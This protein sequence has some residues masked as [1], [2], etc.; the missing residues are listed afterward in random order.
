MLTMQLRLPFGSN[1][2]PEP[3]AGR[4]AGPVSSAARQTLVIGRTAFTVVYFRHRR[5]RHY[6][7]R[8]QGDASL[9][10]TVP[11][12]GTVKEAERFVREKA[13]WIEK[14]RYRVALRRAAAGGRDARRIVLR[15][16][17]CAI[18]VEE[19]DGGAVARA[20]GLQVA[21]PSAGAAPVPAIE[22]QLRRLAAEEL[23]RRLLELANA[24]GHQVT[25][26]TVRGQRTR[27]G[28]C[29]PTGR[30]S[31][32]WRLLQLPPAVADYVL[33]H[34]LTHLR[35][36]NHSR[37]FWQELERVCPGHREARAWLK[38]HADI[39]DHG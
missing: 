30:I 12:G 15:G 7:L 28:S 27:W 24:N 17:E 35:H 36:L 25:G 19:R 23:P 8:L 39:V 26:V 2:P 5:A 31:L 38:A 13:G 34:E 16:V 21:L 33:L 11:R 29:S 37:R 3:P 6:V 18:E 4:P 10:V 9:R 20:G 14:E 32:N 1:R 22:R